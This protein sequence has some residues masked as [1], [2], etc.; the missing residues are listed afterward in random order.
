MN[1]IQEYFQ[2]KYSPFT[3]KGI[4]VEETKSTEENNYDT[5]NHQE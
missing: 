4:P 2:R 1:K 5:L 3:S